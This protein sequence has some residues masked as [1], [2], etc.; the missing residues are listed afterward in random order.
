M[1]PAPTGP[2][3][4]LPED[5]LRS[6]VEDMSSG[7]I[8]SLSLTSKH[9]RELLVP[10]LYRT[11]HLRSSAACNSGLRMLALRPELCAHVRKL[12]VR[13]NYYLAWP[14]RDASADEEWVARTIMQL[15][16]ALRGLRTFDWDGTE[17]PPEGLWRT[18]RS[19]C[20][21]LKEVLANVGHRPI[22]PDSEL[23]NFRA[24]T[25]FSL[26]VR[27]GLG[28]HDLFPPH[29][30]L[31]V[32]LWTML[33]GCPTLAELTLASFS[34]AARLFDLTPLSSARWPQL[35]SLTLGAFGYDHNFGLAGPPAGFDAFLAVHPALTHLRLAWSFQRWMS[36]ADLPPLALP[37]GLIDFSGVAQQ[38]GLGGGGALTTL[39]LMCEPLYEARA[40]AL[41]TAL[42]GLPALT[43]LE[44]WV[45]VPDPLASHAELWAAL[46]GAAPGLEDLHFM[47]TTAFGRKPLAELARA[48]RCLPRLRSFALTKG[49]R[50]ADESMRASAV[51][52]FKALALELTQV[53]V[54]WARAACRNHLKQQGTY[55]RVAPRSAAAVSGD[56][57]DSPTSPTSRGGVLGG[58]TRRR[59][60]DDGKG[61]TEVGDGRGWKGRE[62]DVVEAWE[63][64]LRAVGGAFERRYRFALA[65]PSSAPSSSPSSSP[66]WTS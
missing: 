44:L 10:A 50:Y 60:M 36:P 5:V 6:V 28:E 65:L 51:R 2:Q 34:P 32:R 58:G 42:R 29:E 61:G 59:S 9:I 21:D 57:T 18:L 35:A 8:L 1:G 64:G 11:V 37:A 62:K 40:P 16:P 33:E 26:S 53:S 52:V 54:R 63:R 45:H 4:S 66:S 19:M 49:H 7:D 23:F 27:H 3:A 30:Q 22:L 14:V 39:D 55:E 24:L 46:W 56:G 13:P 31:P 41:C 43:A 47:C 48:L 17:M 12:A 25:T 20:P 15:A 38:L